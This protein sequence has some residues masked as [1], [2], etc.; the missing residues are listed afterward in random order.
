MY[1]LNIPTVILL[2]LLNVASINAKAVTPTITWRQLRN[3][4]VFGAS[5]SPD[6]KYIV[7]G[8]AEAKNLTVFNWQDNKVAWTIENSSYFQ[9]QLSWSP[10]GRYIATWP[11]NIRV[12]DAAN[13]N[14]LEKVEN[15]LGVMENVLG[16]L[17]ERA[18]FV[19]YGTQVKWSSDSTQLAIMAY[20]YIVVYS[21]P[22]DTISL[23]IDLAIVPD[24]RRDLLTLFDWSPDGSKF[25]AFYYQ[26]DQSNRKSFYPPKIGLGF[27][28][29]NLS[30]NQPDDLNEACLPQ[31]VNEFVAKSL[32]IG[33]DIEW[34]PDNNTVAISA[35]QIIVC[36]MK[37]T[38]QHLFSEYSNHL[39]WSADQKWL[40]AVFGDCKVMMADVANNYAI[41]LQPFESENCFLNSAGWSS[42][43]NYVVVGTETGLWVAQ[44]ELPT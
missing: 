6:G 13:G 27:W 15:A 19:Y 12:Y 14:H 7:Y 5:I 22:T 35:G 30:Q 44:I 37:G 10:N 31:N 9:M 29:F 3:E 34:A 26:V 24:G 41:H 32:S 18:E 40:F 8:D 39:Y 23:I 4:K 11:G 43:G 33:N 1:Q 38:A 17:T 36:S 28:N 20:G 42:D 25:A 21:L 2:L 16:L